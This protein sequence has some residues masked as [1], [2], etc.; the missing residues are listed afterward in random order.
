MELTVICGI[1]GGYDPVPERPPGF[2]KAVLVTDTPVHADGWD[3]IIGPT[4]GSPRLSAKLPRM[5]P[6]LFCDTEYSVWMDGT[7]RD[8]SGWT[9]KTARQLLSEGKEFITWQHPMRYCLYEEAE[10]CLNVEKYKD[11][12]LKQ[13]MDSYY[14]EGMPR[15]FG[16]WANGSIARRHTQTVIDIG[17]E[18]LYENIKWS[19]QDQVSLPYVF[20]KRGMKPSAW[21]G[22]QYSGSV[23]WEARHH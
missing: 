19:I 17:N 20:W 22:G 8:S 6:D 10:F 11:Q 12:P 16:L 21:P 23:F 1:Y 14:N 18:W 13:Q 2:D 7:L 3:N 4:L 15:N 5:R 9:A